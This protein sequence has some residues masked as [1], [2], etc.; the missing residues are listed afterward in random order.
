VRHCPKVLPFIVR[1]V[2]PASGLKATS[3]RMPCVGSPG[4]AAN[5][6]GGLPPG[7]SSRACGFPVPILRPICAEPTGRRPSGRW[8]PWP[9]PKVSPG[10]FSKISTTSPN[11]PTS[12][13]PWGKYVYAAIRCPVRAKP[14]SLDFL[15]S[16]VYAQS[17]GKNPYA[18][19]AKRHPSRPEAKATRR[20]C[21]RSRGTVPI[22]AAEKVWVM[23]KPSF[24]AKMGLSP[25]AGK[26][27]GPCF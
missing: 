19:P 10:L 2:S 8:V 25:S 21:N 16:P 11:W 27:T 17:C 20:A 9:I 3:M 26:G 18:Y 15:F 1:P 6:T 5:R 14:Y 12:R 23:K 4:S 22:F 13:R 24:A 7:T